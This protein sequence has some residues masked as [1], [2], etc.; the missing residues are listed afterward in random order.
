MDT[1]EEDGFYFYFVCGSPRN[2]ELHGIFYMYIHKIFYDFVKLKKRCIRYFLSL[3]FGDIRHISSNIV[4]N[5]DNVL[6]ALRCSIDVDGF[7]FV[8]YTT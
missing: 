8:L 5:I 6:R 7:R 4:L 2:E 1:N 3:N